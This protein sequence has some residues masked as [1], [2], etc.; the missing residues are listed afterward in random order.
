MLVTRASIPCMV[1]ARP[2]QVPLQRVVVAVDLS[3]TARGALIVGLSWASAL[4]TQAHTANASTG[5]IA[6]HINESAESAERTGASTN[7]LEEELNQLRRDAG[8]WSGITIESACVAARKL[9][10]SAM[11]PSRPAWQRGRL[12]ERAPR[13]DST[14]PA[15]SRRVPG[16]SR[17]RPPVLGR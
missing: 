14:N 13:S 9:I 7:A 3:D 17:E 5:L 12:P 1:A 15:P 4:R 11:R 8:S 16:G 2:L 10:A 6:L